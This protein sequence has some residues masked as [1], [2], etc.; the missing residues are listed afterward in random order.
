MITLFETVEIPVPFEKLRAWAAN[1]E[2]EFV[3]WSPY[4]LECE[5]YDKSLTI[6]SKVRFY[7]IVMGLDYNVIGT[8]IE[9]ENTED[10]FHY[11][12][13]SENKAAVIIFEGERTSSGCR[14]NH[15]EEFGIR[16]PVI[17]PI[18]NFL[19]FKVFFRKKADWNLIREDM[20][21]DNRLLFEILTEKK[22]PQRIPLEE[23]KK[24]SS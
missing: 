21:L 3:R 24:K 20:I 23:L 19:I 1:F 22:Y 7:E 4:H 8:I 9:S 11:V 14:F 10:R 12:F 16:A 13:Q 5:L 6:G 18:M 17:G 2:E 15:T